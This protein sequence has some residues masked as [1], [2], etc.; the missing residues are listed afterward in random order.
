[1]VGLGWLLGY[2]G[3]WLLVLALTAAGAA[4][5]PVRAVSAGRAP[6]QPALQ[7]R[8]RALGAGEGAAA[9]GS[10]GAAAV[11]PHARRIRRGAGGGGGCSRCCCC[12]GLCAAFMGGCACAHA[13]NRPGSC[14]SK[15][16]RFAFITLL[17][18]L[19]ERID[20]VMLERLA[21]PAEASYYAGAYR[22]VD[23]VMMYALDGAAAVFRPF[24]PRAT[25]QPRRAAA[26]ALVWAA[27]GHAAAAV[28]GGLRAVSGRGAVLAVRAQHPGR[29]S[30]HDPVPA[31]PVSQ[32]AGPCLLRHLQHPAHQHRPRKARELARSGQH[33]PQRRPEFL[34][35]APLRSA[36]RG[37][38]TR[39]CAPYSC[40]WATWGWC[41]GAPAWRCHSGCWA[42]WRWPSPASAPA[43]T[44]WAPTPAC[45]GGLKLPWPRC[46][47]LAL[48]FALGV[49][50]VAEVKAVLQRRKKAE[51]L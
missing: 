3:Y 5:H 6:G 48:V 13:G 31:N 43:G 44:R 21:S 23:A 28:G 29:N 25:G 51:N 46:W 34:A 15:A 8:C 50:R 18:G 24:R 16:C 12:M 2:R 33:C 14:C 27:G 4:V 7:Y 45:P 49:V 9:G 47:L 38:S 20:M 26:A 32:R 35:D 36:G 11:G 37:R 42:G 1:M 39:C 22:W 30:A 10:A 17:Y 19:N 40:R 41:R